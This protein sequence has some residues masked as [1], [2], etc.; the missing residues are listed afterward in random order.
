VFLAARVIEQILKVV[1]EVGEGVRVA[2]SQVAGVSVV[3]EV[4]QIK[5]ENEWVIRGSSRDKHG[6]DWIILYFI[7]IFRSIGIMDYMLLRF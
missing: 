7:Y 1:F 6:Q 5:H 3:W 2:V 4:L